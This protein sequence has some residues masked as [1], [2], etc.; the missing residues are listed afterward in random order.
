MYLAYH[1]KPF[2]RTSAE[3]TLPERQQKRKKRLMSILTEGLPTLPS[4]VF[5]LNTL[6]SSPSVDLKRVAKTIRCDPSMSAQVIRMC[7]SVLFSI[8][9][10]VLNIEEAAIL[11]GSER[12]RT[13]V[14]ACSVMKFA[15]RQ[16]P[17]N[18]VQSFWQHSFMTGLL[19]ERVAK[20]FEYFERE[21]AYLGGLLHDIGALPLLL[22][23]SE[24]NALSGHALTGPWGGSLEEEKK[25]FGM[26]HCEVG[27]WIGQSWKFFP[28]FIDVFENHH[29][30]E[31]STRDPHLVGIVAAAD[32]FCET[33]SPSAS[34]W[35]GRRGNWLPR[36]WKTAFSPCVFPGSTQKTDQ[37]SGNCWKP[38]TCACFPSSNSTTRWDSSRPT[39][40]YEQGD[41]KIEMT[42]PRVLIVDDSSVMRKIIERSLRQAGLDLSEVIEA[43]NG[44]E[45]L[46]AVREGAFDLIL[47]DINMPAMDG[48]EFLRQFC[49]IET[50]KGTPVVMVTTEGSESRVVEA[51]SIGAKGYIRKPFTPDQIRERV[52]PLLEVAR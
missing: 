3:V 13:L 44:V 2:R 9:R 21:Q 50:A 52:C 51:L 36:L 40:L 30:P 35:M 5:E 12:L 24:E 39:N 27:R 15:G 26:T 25:Y 46:A 43:G 1:P 28:S 19:S 8:R 7:N 42:K 14:L 37:N 10:R 18:E 22:V 16:L 47:S 45:A 34:L 17:Q 41:R 48:I 23:A 38:S 29:H 11:M 49:A 6:L 4:Y 20:W 32:H 31:R 33:Y